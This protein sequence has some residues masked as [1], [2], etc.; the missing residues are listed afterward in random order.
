MSDN[1]NS[2]SSADSQDIQIA[3]IAFIG[4]SIVTLGDAISAIAAGLSLDALEN[5][6][7]QKS[8]SSD[9]QS[10]YTPNMQQEVDYI[11]NELKQIKRMMK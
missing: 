9:G 1:K 5:P 4:A 8:K 6:N 11:I 10:M 2:K 7:N 3:R